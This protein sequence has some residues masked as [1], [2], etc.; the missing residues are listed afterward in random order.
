MLVIFI[1]LD[2]WQLHLIGVS[3]AQMNIPVNKIYVHKNPMCVWMALWLKNLKTTGPTVMKMSVIDLQD[4][5]S[6]S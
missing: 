4:S 1:F 2:K 3:N 6:N 5:L